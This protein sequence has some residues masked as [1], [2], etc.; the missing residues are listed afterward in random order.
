VIKFQCKPDDGE[1]FIAE[2]DSRDVLHWEV[3]KNGRHLGQLQATPRMGD[4]IELAWLTAQRT[5]CWHGA[6]EEFREQV[7]VK[8]LDDGEAVEL[9]DPTQPAA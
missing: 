9:L 2:A 5:G 7:A 1:Q 8:P 6:L 3:R 4:M